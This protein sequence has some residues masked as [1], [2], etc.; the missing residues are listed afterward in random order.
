MTDNEFVDLGN[1]TGRL[2]GGVCVFHDQNNKGETTRTS[3][4]YLG[5][6]P[7]LRKVAE[8]RTIAG[9]ADTEKPQNLDVAKLRLV[10]IENTGTGKKWSRRGLAMAA[11][12]GKNPDL[13]RDFISRGQDRKPSFDAVAFAKRL[14]SDLGGM[15]PA[16]GF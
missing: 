15:R 3:S 12:G 1:D 8:T 2:V 14:A 11:S 9:I 6:P 10:I 16:N 4:T 13:V 5:K 7:L